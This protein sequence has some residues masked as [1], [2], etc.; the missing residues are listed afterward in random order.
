V[1]IELARIGGTDLKGD[2]IP[3]V[4]AL[5]ESSSPTDVPHSDEEIPNDP[6]PS[7]ATFLVQALAGRSLTARP[8]D[9]AWS[10][11]VEFAIQ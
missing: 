3:V 6:S 5:L 8:K 10:N 7:G 4:V 9:G 2:G 11:C 1:G